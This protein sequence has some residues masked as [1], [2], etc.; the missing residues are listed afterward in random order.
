MIV[1]ADKP[2]QLGNMLFLFAHFIG[3]AIESD[4]MVS[5][6]AFEDYAEYFPKTRDDLFCRFPA[7]KSLL[8][9]I[10][11]LRKLLYRASSYTVRALA[12][13]GGNFGFLK[14]IRLKDWV[15][16]FPL[17][18]REFLNMVRP[19]RVIF[20]HGWTFRDEA[21]FQKYADVIRDFFR[22]LE[23]HRAN[24]EA[25]MK[26]ARAG[27]EVLVGIHIRHGIIDVA[28]A[29]QYW[30]EP[31]KYAEMMGKVESL[32]PGERVT[33]LIC[34]DKQQESEVF[35]RFRFL[36]GND[37]LVEDMYSFARC[38]YLFGPP[39][40]YTMWASF[41]GKVPLYTVYDPNR[42]PRIEDFV[43]QDWEGT[44]ASQSILH[45][46]DEELKATAP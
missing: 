7:R 14:A 1:I 23:E 29:R 22:P 42:V 21:M 36:F 39:S 38:D 37:Q 30:Y 43:I 4:F 26:R 15:T 19:G 25:L 3:R 18:S 17:D 33:F 20:V 40:T 12:K 5:C 11:V 10:R 32:F 45:R 24:V 8:P 6:L 28:N 2:G 34:S 35:S 44:A 13:A 46:T 41:Y 27:A 9:G 31:Q 16:T